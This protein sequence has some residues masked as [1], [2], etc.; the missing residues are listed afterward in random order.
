M[1]NLF[2]RSRGKKTEQTVKPEIIM[3]LPGAQ[4][5]DS[6]E[7]PAIKYLDMPDGLRLISRDGKYVGWYL[8]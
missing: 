4:F 8:P 5:I 6:S 7:D 1:K 2:R 3:S